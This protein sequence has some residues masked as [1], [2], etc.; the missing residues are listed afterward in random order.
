MKAFIILTFFVCAALFYCST[1]G[2]EDDQSVDLVYVCNQGDGSVSIIDAQKHTV[3]QTL[4]LTD[5]GYSTS[6]KPH[7]VVVSDNGNTWFVSLISDGK[8]LKFNRENELIGEA[9]VSYAGMLTLHPS[10][11]KLFAGRTMSVINVPS[12]VT[13]VDI[14]AMS[15]KEIPLAFSRPHALLAQNNGMYVFS[16]SLSENKIAI[17]NAMTDEVE[18]YASFSGNSVYVQFAVS[19]DNSRLYVTGQADSSLHI[20]NVDGDL[21]SYDRT[22]EVGKA[23]WHPVIAKDGS[24][25]YFG[26]KL[27]NSITVVDLQSYQSSTITGNGLASPHGSAL[28]DDG[29]YLFISN[30]NSNGDYIPVTPVSNP[31]DIGT[32]VVVDTQTDRIIKVIEIGKTPSG[33]GS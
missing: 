14:D 12:S 15:V 13:A 26:N 3:V 2:A 7:H 29:K 10:Q 31:S 30:Q 1:P 9:N 11:K 24:K 8:V 28:S 27:S 6:S 20:F 17:I 5:Y 16:A 4:Q 18:N 25:L 33:M 19:P 22:L 32:V 23:P 21:V